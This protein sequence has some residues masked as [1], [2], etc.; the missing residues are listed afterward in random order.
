MHLPA[1]TVTKLSGGDI[2]VTIRELK[3]P[4]GLQGMLPTDGVPASVTFAD[5]LNRACGPT[6]GEQFRG[7]RS[8]PHPC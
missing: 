8:H 3:D 7:S 1:W 5:Q 2:S 6:P 4:A